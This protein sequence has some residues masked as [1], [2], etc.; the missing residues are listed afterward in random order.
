VIGLFFGLYSEAWDR[1]WQ[2]HLIEGI[3]LPAIAGMTSVTW[4]G[5][6]NLSTML[7]GV[8]AVEIARRRLDMTH[9]PALRRA[10]F[11]MTLVMVIALVV[12]GL[13]GS[14]L[15]ALIAFFA[16]TLMRGVTGPVYD[17][18]SNQHIESR[19]RATVLSMR[20]QTDAVG[21]IAGGPPLGLV[22]QVSLPAAFIG[23]ALL[24][25][26]ILGLLRWMGRRTARSETAQPVEV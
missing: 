23:S 10:L 19:V 17:T 8:V 2:I 4:V 21:Q 11:G 22:G 18:W 5:L 6:L 14:V 26:P 7:L 25:A 13:A 24:L 16:F 20:S 12:F 9:A 15:P 1:L 3:G